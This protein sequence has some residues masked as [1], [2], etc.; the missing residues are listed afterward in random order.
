MTSL[1]RIP[2]SVLRLAALLAAS[3]PAA[4][5]DAAVTRTEYVEAWQASK[6]YTLAVAKAMPDESYGFQ[7]TPDQFTFA[8]QMIHIAHANYAWFTRVLGEP[9]TIADP[10]SEAK[11]DVLPYLEATFDY[12]IAALERITPEQLSRAA[13]GVPNRPNGSGRDA[14]LN[15]Y[16]HIGHHRGQ[17]IIYL[18]L[19]GV[20]PPEYRY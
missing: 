12:C 17:A 13:P 15:M 14:L 8:V 16:M 2:S 9:R 4:A 19:K 11:A 18:R 10:K 7:P 6:A 5:Q 20:T 3:L 1:P